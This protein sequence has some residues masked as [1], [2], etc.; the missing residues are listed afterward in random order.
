MFHRHHFFIPN[1]L[2]TLIKFYV[3]LGYSD[4]EMH[5]LFQ[6]ILILPCS[7]EVE[8]RDQR[9]VLAMIFNA[10]NSTWDEK[11]VALKNRRS[12]EQIN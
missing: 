10:S 11:N 5:H 3:L 6:E 1:N 12:F 4:P 9:L 7:Q 8:Y 2:Q